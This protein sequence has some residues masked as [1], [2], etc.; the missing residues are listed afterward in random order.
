MAA[1]DACWDLVDDRPQLDELAAAL[2]D[3][4]EL[5][6]AERAAVRS[7]DGTE[8]ARV[9]DAKRA[10]CER[11]E[12]LSER[13]RAASAPSGRSI[14]RPDNPATHARRTELEDELARIRAEAEAN[15]ALLADAAAAVGDVIGGRAD[16]GTYDQRARRVTR[17]Q[18]LVGRAV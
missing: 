13:T 10:V 2:G 15:A 8:L 6:D 5:L 18:W 16:T 11:I 12:A 4:G 9:A 17:V 7:L 14:A 3:L 1:R